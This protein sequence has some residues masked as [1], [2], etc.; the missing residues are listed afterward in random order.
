MNEENLKELQES[1]AFSE[2]LEEY[3]VHAQ[4]DDYK[5]SYMRKKRELVLVTE[6]KESPMAT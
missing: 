2:A 6:E 1:N 5:L 3:E 4:N